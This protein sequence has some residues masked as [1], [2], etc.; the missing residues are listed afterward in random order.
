MRGGGGA[1]RSGDAED[2]YQALELA[3]STDGVLAAWRAALEAA[4][5]VRLLSPLRRGAARETRAH[6]Q[7]LEPVDHAIRNLR[8]AL[9]RMVVVAEHGA[10][11]GKG[12]GPLTDV[13]DRLA[14]GVV[15]GPRAVGG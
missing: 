15:T 3:R 1:A 14:G 12:P 8:V 4:E 10:A 7:A 5:E 9:R 11:S 2:A 6:R 13:L